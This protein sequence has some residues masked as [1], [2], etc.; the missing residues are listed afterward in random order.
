MKNWFI[1][2]FVGFTKLTGGLPAYLFFKPKV[3]RINKN[4]TKTPKPCIIV[5][6]HKSLMD[7]A[8]YL[9]VFPFRTVH[10]LI[11][12]VL[13]NKN[14]ALTFMLKAWGGIKVERETHDFAFVSDAI[15]VLDKKGTV[16]IF[17][18]AR[19]PINGKPWPFT[20]SAAFIA[21]HADVPIL[22][23]YTN[24]RY[25]LFKRATVCIGE[26]FFLSQYRQ[27]GLEETQQL[28]HLTDVLE[29]K[30]YELKEHV[31]KSQYARNKKH[32]LFRLKTLPM[33]LARLISLPALL[34]YRIKRLTP[35]GTKYTQKVKNGAILAANHTSFSDPFI[36]GTTFWYR[37]LY[38]LVAEV[39]MKGKL[40]VAMLK[41]AGAI[42]IDRNQADIEAIN[43]SIDKLKQGYL[44]TVFP[45]GGINKFD[46]IDS[47]KSGA[48]LMALRA[49]V[50]I[51][52]MHIH[53]KKHWYSRQVVVIGKTINPSE[54][55]QKKMPSTGDIKAI[56]QAL[57]EQLNL[58]KNTNTG[59]EEK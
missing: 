4:H 40:R 56:S 18:E 51:I 39:V 14:P 59:R 24:G 36:V 34:I 46:E 16:S 44:L 21:T 48:V 22:P 50:P 41:G 53:A 12:E 58:C 13:F 37:R 5:S 47:I 10:F 19:L 2:L 3:L 25:G 27:D 54:Y 52:P 35:E 29:K 15:E 9:I 26:P 17:P 33:D 32:R 30:V 38:F 7:F 55:C 23:V 8:L 42:R 11:A 6:N 20:T 49:N 43:Q 31:E 28:Q 1:H 57:M 45:Q